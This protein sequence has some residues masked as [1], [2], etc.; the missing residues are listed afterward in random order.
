M[1]KKPSLVGIQ[2]LAG[3]F[4]TV[5]ELKDYCDQQYKFISILQKE[6]AAFKVEVDHLKDLLSS[7]TTLIGEIKPVAFEVSNEQAICEMQ[8]R[9]LQQTAE[10]RP[11]TLEETKKLEIFVKSLYL[12]KEKN[13]KDNAEDYTKLPPGVSM[14]NLEKLASIP[15]PKLEDESN[16]S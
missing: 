16:G 14:S 6:N 10:Q 5:A 9:L 11:L 2:V 13:S 7:T 3:Q 8:I 15:A 1:D 4:Q 12:I